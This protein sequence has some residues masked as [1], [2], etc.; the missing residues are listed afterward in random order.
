MCGQHDA[1]RARSLGTPDHRAEIPRVAHLV[2][3]REERRLTGGELERIGVAERLAP[4]D[5]SLVVPRAGGLRQVPFELRLHPRPLDLTQP[6]LA[7]NRPLARPQLE[8][9]A[10]PAQGLPHRTAAVDEIARHGRRTS[11]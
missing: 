11:R 9:L 6:R 2:E 10:W 7:S 1:G 8:N 4:R 3:T 5:D